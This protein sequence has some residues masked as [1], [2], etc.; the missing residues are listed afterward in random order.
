MSDDGYRSHEKQ[1]D[2]DD[3]QFDRAGRVHDW[4]NYIGESVRAIWM[5][6]TPEQRLALAADADEL[7]GREEWD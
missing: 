3:P 4:R 2:V 1:S 6:F 7:A 5:S